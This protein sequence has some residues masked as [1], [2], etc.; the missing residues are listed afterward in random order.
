[1]KR[2][3]IASMM[4]LATPLIAIGIVLAAQDR[5]TLKT[6]NGIAFSEFKGYEKW[7]M[8]APSHPDNA[9]GCA[10]SKEPGCIK[11][12][13]GNP[14]M[15]KAYAEG[16]PAKDKPVPDGAAMVKIEWQKARDP[17]SPY[18]ATVPGALTEVAFMLKDSQRFRETNGWG[19]ATFKYDAATDNWKAF[20]DSP[21]F[22][23]TCH[24]C[25]T[26]VKDRDFVFSRYQKR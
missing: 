21:E 26:A 23:K 1:M 24:S 16:I 9:G 12:I 10:S 25:H 6:P 13:L 14:T 4:I 8:I 22:A 20:G 19:Y 18:G 3:F 5:F 11:S 2:Q 17:E 15:I 7:Q